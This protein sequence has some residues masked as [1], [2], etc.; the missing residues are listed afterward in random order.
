MC[1]KIGSEEKTVT[2]SVRRLNIFSFT[3]NSFFCT[4]SW[5]IFWMKRQNHPSFRRKLAVKV[6]EMLGAKLPLTATSKLLI[7]N[8][9]HPVVVL[10]I[11]NR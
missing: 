3:P 6:D 7:F 4:D 1:F 5:Q 8:T 2:F 10:H 11:K 9:I